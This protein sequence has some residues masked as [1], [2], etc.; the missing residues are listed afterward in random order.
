MAAKAVS[1]V[2]SPWDLSA[3]NGGSDSCEYVSAQP[4]YEYDASR[5]TGSKCVH[6]RFHK[7][8][9]GHARFTRLFDSSS[10]TT[11]AKT[12]TNLRKPS[13]AQWLAQ[14]KDAS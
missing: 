12:G 13:S 2:L 8:R 4:R 1:N 7:S 10:L 14:Q 6:V 3:G 9:R 11:A 5:L